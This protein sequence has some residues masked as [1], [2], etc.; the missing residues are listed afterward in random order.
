MADLLVW[1]SIG[2]IVCLWIWLGVG[3]QPPNEPRS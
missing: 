3:R 2:I 1:L